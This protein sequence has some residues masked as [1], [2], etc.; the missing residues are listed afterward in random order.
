MQN[1]GF[2]IEAYLKVGKDIATDT[3]GN[4]ELDGLPI[5]AWEK[6]VFSVHTA[7]FPLLLC[8]GGQRISFE[9]SNWHMCLQVE[10]ELWGELLE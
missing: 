9:H 5:C 7:A 1:F 8:H 4:L 2:L 6:P 10:W 3:A